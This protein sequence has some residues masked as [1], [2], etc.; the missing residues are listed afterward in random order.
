MTDNTHSDVVEEAAEIG[1]F[2]RFARSHCA[3][4]SP[5]VKALNTALALLGQSA[6]TSSDAVLEERAAIVAWLRTYPPVIGLDEMAA[7]N[8]AAHIERGEHSAAAIRKG[9]NA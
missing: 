2:L 5:A 7:W 6:L 8:T 4:G 3:A 9:D 1:A